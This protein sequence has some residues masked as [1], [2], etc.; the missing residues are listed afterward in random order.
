MFR[1]APFLMAPVMELPAAILHVLDLLQPSLSSKRS[2]QGAGWV[3][4][5]A[6]SRYLAQRPFCGLI[7]VREPTM[8]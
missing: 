2:L 8:G 6:L 3:R 4:L 1:V 7:R 5:T